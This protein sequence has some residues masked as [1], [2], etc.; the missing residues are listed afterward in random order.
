MI[1]QN[2]KLPFCSKLINNFHRH[3]Q[4]QMNNCK[5]DN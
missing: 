1:Q 3:S 5:N 2:F 4:Q